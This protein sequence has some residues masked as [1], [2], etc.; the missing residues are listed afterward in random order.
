MSRNEISQ[1]EKDSFS[2]MGRLKILILDSNKIEMLEESTFAGLVNL[3]E[4]YLRHNPLKS[5]DKAHF[6]DLVNLKLLDVKETKVKV[7]ISDTADTF[8]ACRHKVTVSC[9]G[10]YS[11]LN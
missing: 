11:R 5:L 1:I 8:S 4:L 3:R 2:P 9:D 6:S 7:P 10:Y